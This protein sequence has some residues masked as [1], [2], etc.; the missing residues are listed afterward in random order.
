MSDFWTNDSYKRFFFNESK[1]AKWIS[2]EIIPW[3]QT[4]TISESLRA[5]T[6]FTALKE[7]WVVCKLCPIHNMGTI[8]V[9]YSLRFVKLTSVYLPTGCLHDVWFKDAYSQQ[10]SWIVLYLRWFIF[11]AKNIIGYCLTNIWDPK[12]FILLFFWRPVLSVQVL[13]KCIY[14]IDISRYSLTS[15]LVSVYYLVC[16]LYHSNHNFKYAFYV[17]LYFTIQTLSSLFLQQAGLLWPFQWLLSSIALLKL[18][19]SGTWDDGTPQSRIMGWQ[20]F[21]QKALWYLQFYH[22]LDQSQCGQPTFLS[23]PTISRVCSCITL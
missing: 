12:C 20:S 6:E 19:L 2:T 11:L 9:P 23:T 14:A 10:R 7:L 13:L 15:C 5:I 8:I 21:S 16:R 4:H 17:S 22:R 3:S 18:V 1:M